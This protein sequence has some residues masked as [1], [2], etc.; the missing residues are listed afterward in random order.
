LYN[1]SYKKGTFIK[2]A[3]YKTKAGINKDGSIKY[4]YKKGISSSVPGIVGKDR[5]FM[6]YDI[7]INDVNHNTKNTGKNEETQTYTTLPVSKKFTR[8][9]VTADTEYL[10]LFTDNAGRTSGKG[11]IDPN[12]TYAKEFGAGSRYPSMTQAVIRGLDNSAPI[13]T[14]VDDKRTQWTEDRF[15]EFKDIIDKEFEYIETKM[16]S[17]NYKGIKFSDQKPFGQG[18]Y[19]KLP[20][21]LQR[22]LDSKLLEI[23]I[24]NDSGVS[25][26]VQQQSSQL[27]PSTSSFTYKGKTIPTEF[28]LS[29]DQSSALK[30]LIDWYTSRGTDPIV[31]QGPAGTGKT[32]VIG[33]FQ[34]YIGSTVLYTAPTHA[35]TLQ[36]T[37]AAFKTGSKKLA[38]T[39]R[40]SVYRKKQKGKKDRA[41]LTI[42]ASKKLGF[43]NTIVVDESSMVGPEEQW[44]LEDLS[45]Q[46]YKIIYVGDKMQIPYVNPNNPRSKSLTEVFTKYENVNLE[47][48][49]RT[50]DPVLTTVLNKI[51]NSNVD[52]L[53]KTNDSETATFYGTN[54]L[55]FNQEYVRNLKKNPE[56]VIFIAYNNGKVQE[57]NQSSREVLGRGISP[58]VGD[59]ITGYLSYASKQIEKGHLAN[60]VIYTITDINAKED[61]SSAKEIQFT[62]KKL[63]ELKKKGVQGIPEA[64]DFKTTYYQLSRDDSFNFED[65]NQN[66]FDKNNR[67]VSSLFRE[68]HNEYRL[69]LPLKGRNYFVWLETLDAFKDIISKLDLGNTYIYNPSSNKM[70]KFSRN[71]HRKLK[72]QFPHLFIEK[73]A[74]YGHA[75]TAHKSQGSTYDNVFVD[76]NSFNSIP[77]TS[78]MEDGKQ[79]NTEK[80]AVAYVAL[81]RNS[82]KLHVYEGKTNFK[83]V[84]VDDQVLGVWKNRR[85]ATLDSFDT[86]P[87]TKPDY[88]FNPASV[89]EKRRNEFKKFVLDELGNPS[90]IEFESK[91]GDSFYKF[92][93]KDGTYI[94][95]PAKGRM[96]SYPNAPSNKIAELSKKYGD[97]DIKLLVGLNKL[98]EEKLKQQP[99]KLAPKPKNNVTVEYKGNNYSVDF[100]KGVITN[101]KTN[102]VLKGGVTSPAGDAIF[103]LALAQQEAQQT[104]KPA[105]VEPSTLANSNIKWAGYMARLVA[106]AVEKDVLNVFE[107]K[108]FTLKKPIKTKNG[109]TITEIIPEPGSGKFTIMFKRPT[110]NWMVEIKRGDKT[111]GTFKYELL[112]EESNK[113]GSFLGV[114]NTWNDKR[115]LETI[116]ETL[117]SDLFSEIKKDLLSVPEQTSQYWNKTD[118]EY[119]ESIDKKYG[120][121]KTL[122]DIIN[123][124]ESKDKEDDINDNTTN[125]P[126]LSPLD[127]SNDITNSKLQAQQDLDNAINDPCNK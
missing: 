109:S 69:L 75:I 98:A 93:F 100:S 57:V 90:S 64:S 103:N 32:S 122:G 126:D 2:T 91:N 86:K 27:Q 124:L 84:K 96:L 46:G 24:V 40:S 51:R 35:A 83:N 13:T 110:G 52:Q 17:G 104:T 106:K 53:Y 60:S 114:P 25:N 79:I 38:S 87:V 30:D 49:H 88:N 44:L 118:F 125:T 81:S 59:I 105:Q 9:S 42:K 95:T 61:D 92:T 115:I 119:N 99:T 37:F 48:I 45:K 80:Q 71:K 36:L 107:L 26:E 102:K 97:Y 8:S 76:A 101:L 16:K 10:Y 63:E 85:T 58:E 123:E 73:G 43:G 15:D 21:N 72:F 23:G 70:E 56:E 50:K 19:S 111:K 7:N 18:T 78:I 39:I 77:R 14:M 11:K 31:L 1:I 33:Y 113:P 127:I 65:L 41:V 22:Y 62:S 12:S 82:K 20:N 3:Y 54:E 29:K 74:D 66:D 34:K 117:P 6:G 89:S 55:A 94:E 28:E 68:L 4:V 5:F 112:Y 108:D 47:K 67:T 120:I 116:T 121:T